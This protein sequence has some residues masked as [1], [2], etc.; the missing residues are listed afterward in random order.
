MKGEWWIP[1][2]LC[3]IKLLTMIFHSILVS[4][5]GWYCLQ[6]RT[7]KWLKKLAGLSGSMGSD[8]WYILS[9]EAGYKCGFPGTYPG[10]CPL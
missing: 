7:T 1:S 3:L 8:S 10:T 6:G 2:T 9:L 5:L 4:R